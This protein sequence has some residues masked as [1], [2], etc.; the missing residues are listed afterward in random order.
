M[1]KESNKDH[2]AA[3]HE[4]AEHHKVGPKMNWGTIALVLVLV[5]CA[6]LVAT[7]AGFTM[8]AASG[9]KTTAN[10][11]TATLSAADMT[12]LSGNVEKYINTNLILDANVKAKII[13]TNNLG[14]GLYQLNYEIYQ[15]GS[16][17]SAGSVYESSGQ[18][19]I[20]QAFDLAKPL[21][22]PAD[23]TTQQP[24]SAAPVKT[25]K[26]KVDLYV[27][28]FCPYGNQAE[29]TFVPDFNLLKNQ[30]D[31]NVHFIVAVDGN[32]VQSLHGP[33]EVTEDMREACVAKYY[34]NVSWIN[35]AVYVNN[36][37]GQ[38]SSSTAGACWTDAAKAF[39][40]D[41]NKISTCVA[42]EGLQL[43]KDNEAA[44]NAAGAQGSPTMIINGVNS[45]AVYQYGNSEAYK[46]AIC[47]SFNNAPAECSVALSANTSTTQGGS[48]GN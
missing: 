11:N 45:T 16:K 41:Q 43:M 19:I 40:I 18:L 34:G 27:M 35:F 6:T 23:S 42:S 10:Q 37:C 46:Q 48:C 17:V 5:F 3:H 9:V 25:D 13:D 31:F 26:P 24:A 8:G 28:S 7:W 12:A 20:G 22:K 2:H 4:H 47:G 39:N 29:D 44:S 36:N 32:N 30:I 15:N 33:N 14:N 38:S 1:E 21:P